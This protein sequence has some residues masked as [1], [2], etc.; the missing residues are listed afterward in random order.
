[1]AAADPETQLVVAL[2]ALAP[3]SLPPTL[4]L[5]AVADSLAALVARSHAHS[6]APDQ[7]QLVHALFA[8]AAP[9]KG[10]LA[11]VRLVAHYLAAFLPTNAALA[12]QVAH[13]ALAANPR[14]A[15]AI[16]TQVHPALQLALDPLPAGADATPATTLLA[17]VQGTAHDCYAPTSPAAAAAAAA[18]VDLLTDRY[19]HLAA[20]D[21]AALDALRLAV[22]DTAHTLLTTVAAALSPSAATSIALDTLRDLLAVLLPRGAPPSP[23]A[24]DLAAL[25]HGAL[26]AALADAVTGAV[27]PTARQ[28][29]DMLGAFRRAAPAN[30]DGDGAPAPHEWLDR[31]RRAQQVGGAADAQVGIGADKGEG[32][33]LAGVATARPADP[34]SE[35]ELASAISHLLDL[36]PHLPP[37]FL[38]AALL[39]PSFAAHTSDS[40]LERTVEALVAALL[41]DAPLAADLRALREGANALSAAAPAPAPAPAPASAPAPTSASASRAAGRSARANIHDEDALFTRGVLLPAKAAR[42]PAAAAAAGVALDEALKASII[43]L[44]EAPSSDEDDDEGEAFLEGDED[45]GPRVRVGE[46]DPG[47]GEGSSADE[48]GDDDDE[49]E[50]EG[51]RSAGRGGATPA[52]SSAPSSAR[53]GGAGGAGYAPGVQLALERAYLATPEVFARD[54]AT[55][56]AKARRALREQTGLGDEQI[57]GWRSMLERDVRSLPLSFFGGGSRL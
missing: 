50:E 51:R 13:D 30:G 31:L 9:V 29:K 15:Q 22:V 19:A 36:F 49:E 46:G 8:R 18:L 54:A 41:D 26:P 20:A 27:G 52:R 34:E 11:D 1:M 47:D 42:K 57:E 3:S 6:H 40:G 43:A 7:R 32:V 44:A 48:D 23:L 17:L 5:P 14:L 37:P 45:A 16:R 4:G 12:A 24:H 55:R 25:S 10:A 21:L 28:V 35:A 38:R 53:A 2:L 33:A 56:R 39:H